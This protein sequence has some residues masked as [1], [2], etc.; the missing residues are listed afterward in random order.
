MPKPR[1]LAD[2]L[3]TTG[4]RH[5]RSTRDTWQ[6]I[7]RVACL[8]TL[9]TEYLQKSVCSLASSKMVT[10][11]R[12]GGSLLSWEDTHM[13]SCHHNAGFN[14]QTRTKG[15]RHSDLSLTVIMAWHPCA[16]SLELIGRHL[17]ATRTFDDSPLAIFC[18]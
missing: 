13:R 4:C 6:L 2:A 11:H 7:F 12:I 16:F 17:T 3:K 15:P 10:E 18:R 9:C 5:P 1:E 14:R 8:Y